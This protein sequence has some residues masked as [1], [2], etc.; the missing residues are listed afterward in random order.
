VPEIGRTI[1]H[2]SI[3]E[4]LGAGVPSQLSQAVFR[5]LI[6]RLIVM[7]GRLDRHEIYSL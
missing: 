2:Y 3:A 4:K 5:R 6:P 7:N 1:S